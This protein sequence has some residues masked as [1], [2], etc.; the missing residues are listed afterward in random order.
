MVHGKSTRQRRIHRDQSVSDV[1]SR[2]MQEE[3]EENSRY[4]K[5]RPAFRTYDARCRVMPNA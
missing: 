2:Q 3:V 4:R 5:P 1:P